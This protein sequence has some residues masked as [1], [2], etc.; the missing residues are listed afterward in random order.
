[1][2]HLLSGNLIFF[3]KRHFMRKCQIYYNLIFRA[4]QNHFLFQI[5]KKF[6]FIT[7]TSISYLFKSALYV[8]SRHLT[9]RVCRLTNE[10][11]MTESG[12]VAVVF[13]VNDGRALTKIATPTTLLHLR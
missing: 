13:R 3:I 11:F 4:L 2:K 7:I 1:M 12:K 5:T 10:I 9:D 6:Y 8:T